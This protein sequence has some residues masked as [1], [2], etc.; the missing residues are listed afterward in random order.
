M[1][2]FSALHDSNGLNDS[3]SRSESYFEK[4]KVLHIILFIL[5]TILIICLAI[6][7]LVVL[8]RNK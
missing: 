8:E 4:F 7:G 2:V 5:L 6:L 1:G 3:N